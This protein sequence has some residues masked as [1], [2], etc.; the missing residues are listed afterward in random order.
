MLLSVAH[1]CSSHISHATNDKID[2]LDGRAQS[3]QLNTEHKDRQDILAWLSSLDFSR[4]QT[5]LSNGR[6]Q[7]T[8]SWLIESEEFK[9]WSGND[10][11][12]LICQ[13]IPGAGQ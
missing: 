4:Q 12:S 7:G 2:I 1:P 10:G 9:K 6:Q 5:T 13:G 3:L 11:K 8:G